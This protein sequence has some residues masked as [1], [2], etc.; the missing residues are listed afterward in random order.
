MIAIWIAVLAAVILAGYW[1]GIRPLLLQRPAFAD[2]YA[3]TDS[4]WAA[5]GA[6]MRT[7]RT[8]LLTVL[9]VIASALVYFDG[10]LL[11]LL[12]GV[13]WT[14]I[15]KMAPDWIWPFVSGGWLM[16]IFY[17][18]SM[19]DRNQEQVVQAVASGATPEEAKV[20]VGILPE[21]AIKPIEPGV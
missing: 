21:T 17:F 18:K 15:T 8:K 11:P 16:L 13:D 5:L 14:P 6:K 4:F 7:I 1:F 3:Q 10:S 9:G 2:F 12:T 19:G 20:E